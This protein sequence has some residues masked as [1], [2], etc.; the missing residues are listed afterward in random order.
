MLN[1]VLEVGFEQEA[2][3]DNTEVID[4]NEGEKPQ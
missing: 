3:S 2:T 1:L 4:S